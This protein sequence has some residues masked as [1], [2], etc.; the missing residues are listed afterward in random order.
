MKKKIS[1]LNVEY[2][3]NDEFVN[4][5]SYFLKNVKGVPDVE[6]FFEIEMELKYSQR[7]GP[8]YPHQTFFD[9]DINLYE[10]YNFAWEFVERNLPPDI[11]QKLYLWGHEAIKQIENKYPNSKYS[12]D[13]FERFN[14]VAIEEFITGAADAWYY[15][16]LKKELV[17]WQFES[18]KNGVSKKKKISANAIALFCAI[19]NDSK[20]VIKG[21]DESK[22]DYCKRVCNVYNLTYSDNIR[23]LFKDGVPDIKTTNKQFKEVLNSILPLLVTGKRTLIETYLNGRTKLYN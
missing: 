7:F 21:S 9:E 4:Q 1:L 16:W 11:P 14:K 2:L 5:Q 6:R 19:V 8:E 17:Q 10:F 18:S 22:S 3:I 13:Y 12:D 15:Y 20:Q 23:Q